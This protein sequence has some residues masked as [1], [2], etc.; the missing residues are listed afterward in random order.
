M[1][2]EPCCGAPSGTHRYDV[3]LSEPPTI[4]GTTISSGVRVEISR[5]AWTH[6]HSSCVLTIIVGDEGD[7]V[8]PRVMFVRV[9]RDQAAVMAAALDPGNAR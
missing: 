8:P 9:D 2:Y 6:D 5:N 3:P 4:V 7:E 1:T